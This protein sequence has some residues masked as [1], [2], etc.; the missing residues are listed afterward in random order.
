MYPNL[1]VHQKIH[2]SHNNPENLN[3][4]HPHQ[5]LGLF[6]SVVWVLVLALR[7]CVLPTTIAAAVSAVHCLIMMV[8][9][10][11]DIDR[12]VAR[13]LYQKRGFVDAGGKLLDYYADGRHAYKMELDFLS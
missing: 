5:S 10:H 3:T 4:I 2:N 9:L 6:L 1:N 7:N 12:T 8:S 13:T 11:V